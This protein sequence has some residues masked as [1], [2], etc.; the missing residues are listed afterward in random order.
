MDQSDVSTNQGS[1]P[2]PE[3]RRGPDQIL[4]ISLV[5]SVTLLLNGGF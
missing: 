5:G 2:P 3:V 4:P 1:W